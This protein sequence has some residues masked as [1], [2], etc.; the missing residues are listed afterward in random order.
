MASIEHIYSIFNNKI[1]H[2][3]SESSMNS[4]KIYDN[5]DKI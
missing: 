3:L 1:K 5:L 4:V 2:T